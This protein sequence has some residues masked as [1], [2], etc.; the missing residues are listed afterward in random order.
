[1]EGFSPSGIL[2]NVAMFVANLPMIGPVN[3]AVYKQR[4]QARYRESP[5]MVA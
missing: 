4:E 1:M 2:V 3:I 5:Q